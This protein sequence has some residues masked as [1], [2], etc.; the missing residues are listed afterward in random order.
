MRDLVSASRAVTLIGPGGI[1]KTTL[2]IELARNL[3][4]EFD[5]G[6]FLVELASLSDPDLVPSTV[7]TTLGLKVEGTGVTSS[8]IARAIGTTKLL[9]VLDNCE[10]VID[11]SASLAP[12]LFTD[13]LLTATTP[14]FFD[15]SG[16]G[17]FIAALFTGLF[18]GTIAFAFVADR[19]GRRTVF[20]YS[21]LWYSIC[22]LI[23][24]FQDTAASLMFWR[25]VGG[26]GIGVE[27]VTIDAYVS[28]L[29]PKASRGKAFAYQLGG[30]FLA[31]PTVA[32]FAWL[33]VLFAP[34]GVSGWRW[35]LVIGSLGAVVIW[36]IRRQLPESP[37]WLAQ[38]GRLAEA[39]A[40]MARIEAQVEAQVGRPLAPPGP[41]P[42]ELRR[43]GRYLEIFEPVYRVRTVM[44]LVFNFGTSIGFYGFANWVPTLLIAQGIQVTRSLEYTFLIALAYPIFAFL[45]VSF[46]DRTERKWQL[47]AP[48]I[49][50]AV[51]GV[52]FSLQT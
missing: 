36:T 31:V 1:G 40:I 34:L 7:A 42:T 24:A 23:L 8:E 12:G 25:L 29:V 50:T 44:M 4:P 27:L 22:S 21:L 5:A 15:M 46:A 20:T 49:G 14:G 47:A 45:G 6:A 16:I 35:V 48:S 11:A 13:K 19:F 10:H 41:A 37:R 18:I 32:F 2:A 30:G 51:C 52:I 38:R 17:A 43:P 26:I 9:L 3:L 33:L 28:E 39:E